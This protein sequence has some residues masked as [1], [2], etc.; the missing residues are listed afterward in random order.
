MAFVYESLV[1]MNED[2]DYVHQDVKK[3]LAIF[4]LSQAS[5]R[6]QMGN[7][8]GCIENYRSY[9]IGTGRRYAKDR[10]GHIMAIAEIASQNILGELEQKLVFLKYAFPLTY[11]AVVSIAEDPTLEWARQ[12]ARRA[13]EEEW[14]IPDE[15]VNN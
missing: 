13:A 11:A 15:E 10:G 5:F 6:F 14:M 7:G 9:R 1:R 4:K 12:L 3:M 2:C 8:W